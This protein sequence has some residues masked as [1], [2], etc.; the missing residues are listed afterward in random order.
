M[1]PDDRAEAR[2]RVDAVIADAADDLDVDHRELAALLLET[3]DTLILYGRVPAWFGNVDA[4][5]YEQFAEA[6]DADVD[7]A[8]TGKGH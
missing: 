1:S 8:V 3:R 7:E 6:T 2:R 5:E 4:V